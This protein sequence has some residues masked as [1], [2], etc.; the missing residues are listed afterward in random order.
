MLLL[1]QAQKINT[2]TDTQDLRQ[3]D[4]TLC[5]LVATLATNQCMDI[6]IDP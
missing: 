4:V 6:F 1:A 3:S 5:W 2:Q